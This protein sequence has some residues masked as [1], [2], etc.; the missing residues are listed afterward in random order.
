MTPEQTV[1]M[2]VGCTACAIT[3]MVAGYFLGYDHGKVSN[4]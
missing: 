3:G 2:Y 1:W 4:Q